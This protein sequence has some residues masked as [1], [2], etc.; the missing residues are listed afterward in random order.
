MWFG[1]PVFGSIE[2]I[3]PFPKDC[4]FTWRICSASCTV[5]VLPASSLKKYVGEML[6]IE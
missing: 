3:K 2:L 4:S 5:I 6:N 1:G